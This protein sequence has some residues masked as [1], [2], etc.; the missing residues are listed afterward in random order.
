[1]HVI[2]TMQCQILH[3]I[4]EL[5]IREDALNDACMNVEIVYGYVNTAT[6]V[7]FSVELLW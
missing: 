1:M 7:I 4:F 6:K 2:S 3:H 5:G